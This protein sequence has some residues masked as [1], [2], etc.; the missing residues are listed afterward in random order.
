MDN[1]QRGE[2]RRRANLL[3]RYVELVQ[4]SH[5]T[6]RPSDSRMGFQEHF[7]EIRQTQVVLHL[8]HLLATRRT[9]IRAVEP[10][11]DARSAK[12]VPTV[13]TCH[14]VVVD[15]GTNRARQ[16]LLENR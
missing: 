16:L 2:E 3:A 8:L 7:G 4:L 10:L 14:G 9:P 11:H 1:L 13:Q 15:G 12:D 6:F 5:L